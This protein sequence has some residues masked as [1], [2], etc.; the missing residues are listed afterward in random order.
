MS[1]D[2]QACAPTDHC[3]KWKCERAPLV[4]RGRYWC[5][6]KCGDSYGENPHPKLK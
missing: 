3:T 4:K 5:C 2:E 1:C 6:P